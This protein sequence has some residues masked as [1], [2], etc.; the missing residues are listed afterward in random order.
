MSFQFRRI[1]LVSVVVLAGLALPA[2]AGTAQPAAPQVGSPQT[3]APDRA[4]TK[5]EGATRAGNGNDST[6]RPAALPFG[7]GYEQRR[8]WLQRAQQ[9]PTFAGS[10]ENNGSAGDSES[11]TSAGSGSSSGSSGGGRG[12]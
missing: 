7:A 3:A 2:W 1:G 10:T 9:T 6:E 5:V 4:A 12:H 11:G 8:L